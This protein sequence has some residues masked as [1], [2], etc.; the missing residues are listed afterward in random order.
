MRTQFN[1]YRVFFEGWSR[2][3]VHARSLGY[4]M[5]ESFFRDTVELISEILELQPQDVVLDAGCG[6]GIL[7]H[8]LAAKVKELVAVDY[9]STLVADAGRSSVRNNLRFAVA[10][11]GALPFP[12]QSFD[13]VCC[14]DVLHN[15]PCKL[16]AYA[17]IAE[18]VRVCRSGG[19]ILLGDVP[20]LPLRSKLY[21]QLCRHSRGWRRLRGFLAWITPP[22]A[23]HWIYLHLLRRHSP[24][25]FHPGEIEQ[26]LPPMTRL[27]SVT[28]QRP[29]H[30][31]A[32]GRANFL[33]VKI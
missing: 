25:W 32:A 4:S 9:V 2:L 11:I 10:G 21:S 33:A 8:G 6:G 20:I 31:L 19:K 12:D 30:P 5:P 26:T 3:P 22:D 7:A 27:V 13:K 15:Q 28:P 24:L 17:V 1:P 23:K 16:A 14:Y 29:L 18:L